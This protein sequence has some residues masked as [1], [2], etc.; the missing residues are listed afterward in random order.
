MLGIHGCY[1]VQENRLKL[2]AL[3]TI[4]AIMLEAG[5]GSMAIIKEQ[6]I[7][8]HIDSTL[9]N[10]RSMNS[11]HSNMSLLH[12]RQTQYDTNATYKN[13]VDNVHT[14][15][16]CCSFINVSNNISSCHHRISGTP[17]PGCVETL[18]DFI[19]IKLTY[20]RCLAFM[21][22]PIQLFCLGFDLMVLKTLQVTKEYDKLERELSNRK[23]EKRNS[24]GYTTI[25]DVE[26]INL[27]AAYNRVA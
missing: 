8:D 16:S 20:I 5:L 17:L 26:N 6:S 15:L 13:I 23:R 1:W 14:E 24:M 21:L 25:G 18:R 7:M 10:F 27:Q 22:V 11:N 9:E 4:A 2:Y 12:F 19:N 3:S